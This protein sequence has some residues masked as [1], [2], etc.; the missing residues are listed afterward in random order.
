MLRNCLR[1]SG[2]DVIVTGEPEGQICKKKSAIFCSME[3]KMIFSVSAEILLSEA[4]RAQRVDQ[5]SGWP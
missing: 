5:K 4:S 1:D 3:T 2:Q